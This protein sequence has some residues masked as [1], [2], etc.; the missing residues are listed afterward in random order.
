M[1]IRAY[2]QALTPSCID[3]CELSLPIHTC[4]DRLATIETRLFSYC[5]SYHFYTDCQLST[6]PETRADPWQS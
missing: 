2:E 3:I 5:L 1:S 6:V 4:P